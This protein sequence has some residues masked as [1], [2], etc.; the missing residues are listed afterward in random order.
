MTF[1]LPTD[2]ERLLAYAS[3]YASATAAMPGG[4]KAAAKFGGPAGVEALMSKLPAS[5]SATLLSGGLCSGAQSAAYFAKLKRSTSATPADGDPLAPPEHGCW[6]SAGW[7][8][9]PLASANDRLTYI[10]K[11]DASSR[12]NG[13]YL[14]LT[15]DDIKELASADDDAGGGVGPR[16]ASAGSSGSTD[17]GDSDSEGEAH[18]QK[19][20]LVQTYIPRPLLVDNRKFDLRIYVMVTSAFPT[21]RVFIYRQGLVRFATED[22]QSPDES[23]VRCVPVL[24]R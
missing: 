10:V 15:L 7:Q 19:L 3:A 18:L 14:A 13:I 17:T 8:A 23:N 22:Y 11:P 21:M 9:Q 16:A 1:V 4:K 5:T 2:K 20:T 12:G 24:A 6:P